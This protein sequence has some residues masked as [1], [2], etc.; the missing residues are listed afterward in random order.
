MIDLTLFDFVKL[1]EV[2]Y[3]KQS[4]A[5]GISHENGK[6]T[7]DLKSLVILSRFV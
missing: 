2:I 4:A 7:R 6:K 5:G 3:T 1:L